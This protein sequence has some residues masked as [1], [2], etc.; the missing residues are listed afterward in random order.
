MSKEGF[1]I[2]VADGL[3]KIRKD[4]DSELN[5]TLDWTDWLDTDTITASDT[6][7]VNTDVAMT[8]A[9]TNTGVIT[10]TA[11]NFN[12]NFRI[13][14]LITVS[15]FS[16]SVNNGQYRVTSVSANALGVTKVVEADVLIDESAGPSIT[17]VNPKSAWLIPAPLREYSAGQ[18]VGNTQA[19]GFIAG[20]VAG[21]DYTI[22]NRI[23]TTNNLRDE[24]SFVLKVTSK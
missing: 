20:G 17:L 13:N 24:R 9:A 10:S 4:S 6:T 15:G 8:S 18:V 2:D 21:T 1:Y 22:V 19:V 7:D 11:I 3:L 14:D 16:N 12:T 23:R 5:Y